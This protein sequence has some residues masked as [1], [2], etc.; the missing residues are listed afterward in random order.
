M[1]INQ[2]L[3][4][5]LW[6]NT[7]ENY[8]WFSGIILLSIVFKRLISKKLSSLIYG[9]FKRYNSGALEI[10][11]LFDLLVKPI[12]LL[13][14]LIGFSFAFS[15]L[16]FPTPAE[17]EMGLEDGI[18]IV[19]QILIVIAVTW[20][21]LRLID[22]I[23]HVLEKKAEE[24]ETKTDDQII[25]FAREALKILTYIFSF[26]FLLGA[27][28]KLNI[29]GLVAGLGIGGLA[30]ALAAQDT[31]ENVIASFIIFFDKPFV[32]GDFISVEG[33]FG[34]VEKI[35]F[36]STRIRTLEKSYLSM[37]NKSLINNKLDNL[38]LRTFRRARFYVGLTYDTGIDQIKA[39]V[40]DT[41]KLLDDH[42]KTNQDGLV[43]FEEFGDSSLNV[44]VM[45]YVDT[46]D[47]NEFMS[48]RQEVNFSI[49]EIVKK[50]G[51]DFA[52]PST[53]VYMQK[54]N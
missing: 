23:G 49:M 52:F 21:V 53:T 38:S 34:V 4:F 11:K 8:L 15:M 9:V 5:A 24:T 19:F 41:Q 37:P 29:G 32:V 42:P 54:E 27:V 30:F 14:V 33:D 13:I 40:S 51:S 43:S 45:M 46:T 3:N 12:E 18:H 50:H 48:V 39:I 10:E 20:I 31:L 1:D 2:I 6:G 47:Y 28:F 26:L 7:F 16:H 36:R 22:F 35:G 25:Q 44:M 17:G